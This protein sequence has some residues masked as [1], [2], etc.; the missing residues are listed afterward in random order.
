MKLN[1]AL[2]ALLIGAGMTVSTAFAEVFVR[3]AP[4]RAIVE[5]RPSSPGPGYVWIPGYHNWDGNRHVWVSGRWEMAPRHHA[6]W[7]PHHWVRRNGGWVLVE[8]HWR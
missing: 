5:H 4:P 2:A 6:R 8:G 7:E 1:K 3:V